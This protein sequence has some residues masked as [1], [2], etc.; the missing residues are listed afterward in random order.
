MPAR[1]NPLLRR[2]TGLL[3]MAILA[4]PLALGQWNDHAVGRLVSLTSR[5]A[6][7]TLV[8]T[9]ESLSVAATPSLTSGAGSS[10]QMES[11]SPAFSITT[12]WAMPANA[13]TFR[14]VSYA[15]E[16]A[17]GAVR[18]NGDAVGLFD[19]SETLLLLD[20]GTTGAPK[21]RTDAVVVKLNGVLK[22]RGNTGK[23]PEVCDILVQAL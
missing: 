8:V 3:A 15:G 17:G 12:R 1:R 2:V 19:S 21:T 9:L 11:A 5:S 23:R 22:G 4:A 18:M 14:L 6:A 7:V 20:S 10:G 13:T 16:A